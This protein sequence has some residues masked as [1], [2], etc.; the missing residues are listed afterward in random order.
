MV[1]AN[2]YNTSLQ[3]VQN[4]YVKIELLDSNYLTV[5]ELSGNVVGGNLTI[6]AESDMRRTGSIELVVTDSSFEVESGGKIFLDKMLKVSIGIEIGWS[7]EIEWNKCGLFIIDAPSYRYDT[8]TNTLSLSLLDLMAKLT[9]VRNGYLSG[10]AVIISAGENIRKAMIDTLALGGFTKYIMEDSGDI[11]TDIE[12]AQGTTVYDILSALRDI[13]PFYQ[14]YFDVDGVFHYEH[15]P[16]DRNEPIQADDYLWDNIVISEGV[17]VDFQNVKNSV[18]VWG[19]VHDPAYFSNSVTIS[20]NNITLNIDSLSPTTETTNYEQ[21][22]QNEYST[23]IAKNQA[24]ENYYNAQL[25][26]EELINE[27]QSLN[28]DLSRVIYGNIDLDNRQVLY[29]NSYTLSLYASVISAWEEYFGSPMDFVE[30]DISTVLGGSMWIIDNEV[31]YSPLLQTQDTLP[32]YLSPTQVIEY[33]SQVVSQALSMSG[34][35]KTNILNIDNIGLTID[36]VLIKQIVAD[37][38]DTA[39]WTGEVMHYGG[40][41]GA[42]ALADAEK[43]TTQS[44]YQ[45]ALTSYNNAKLNLDNAYEA[46]IA[47]DNKQYEQDIIYGFT[48]TLSSNIVAP[49]IRIN[50]GS[51]FPV[52][53]DNGNPITIF[54]ENTEVYY[55]VLWDI[56]HWRWLGHLQ[57]FGF[58]E[59]ISPESPFYVDGSVGRIRLVLYDGEYANCITDDLA[60]QRANYEL[61]QHTNLNNTITLTTTPV[62]WLDVNTVVE[63]TLRRK[64]ET[65][66]YL[67]KN[68]NYGFTV[69]SQMTITMFKYYFQPPWS[70]WFDV[71]TTNLILYYITQIAPDFSIDENGHLIYDYSGSGTLDMEIGDDGHLYLNT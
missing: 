16:T 55:C 22:A 64:D 45:N 9:G 66:K 36:G 17:D 34:D 50:T 10:T 60:Q 21:A 30:G 56:D 69:D 42:V 3:K 6:D 49:Q 67:I 11:P 43:N 28:V 26:Y 54:G 29:W 47:A 8:Q 40:T 70:F 20:N 52:L 57:A 71:P 31:A 51:Y 5:D 1:T 58:N 63:Y 35:I 24:Y 12:F 44:A 46:L 23:K 18:E 14:I 27:A 53:N 13:Y 25:N 62:Y 19:R 38:G 68:I 7:G 59:D 32:I 48:L 41:N 33:L 15:I 61:W 39:I 2:Q 4:R 65:A 37:Y